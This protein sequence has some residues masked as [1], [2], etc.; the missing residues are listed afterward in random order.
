MN[1]GTATLPAESLSN[2][3]GV[4][5]KQ[6]IAAGAASTAVLSFTKGPLA[7]DPTRLANFSSIGP[8]VDYS[9]K[10]DLVAVG[11]NYYVATQSYDANG[12]MY[13]SNGY[14]DVDG[15]SFAAPTVAGSA[16][17]LK[18]ARPG[19]TVAQYRS[20]LINS[21]SALNTGIGASTVQLVG[22]GSLNTGAALL[23]TAAIYPTS[24]SFGVG[25]AFPQATSTLQII[26]P[27]RPLTRLL[28][29][30]IRR[31]TVRQFLYPLMRFALPREPQ[32]RWTFHSPDPI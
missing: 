1:V 32:V 22:A 3:D 2:A 7:I 12:E 13:S 31:Q 20:M 27:A 29:P 10:P 24:L 5:I 19:F 16:A 26:I 28:L 11:T 25:G 8:N 18:A 4:A 21:A 15:T 9:I 6:A 30:L 14:I 23:S 17:L